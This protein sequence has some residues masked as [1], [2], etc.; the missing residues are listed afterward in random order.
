MSENILTVDALDR[1]LIKDTYGLR[2]LSLLKIIEDDRI[3]FEPGTTSHKA[4]A[5]MFDLSHSTI[6]F[7]GRVH[8]WMDKDARLSV[9][10]QSLSSD[11]KM[12]RDEMFKTFELIRVM[13]AELHGDLTWDNS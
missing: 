12:S 6:G 10:G 13:M 3:F 4:M 1:Y 11:Y 7:A 9:G 5:I 8:G 2:V